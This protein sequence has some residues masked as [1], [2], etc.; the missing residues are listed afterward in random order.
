LTGA[1]DRILAGQSTF[2][3]ELQE[4]ANIL[5]YATAR[6]LVIVDE[7]G[8]GTSTYDGCAAVDSY[9]LLWVRVVAVRLSDVGVRVTSDMPSH[10]E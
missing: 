4:T 7:L 9:F 10:S 1:S 6:S 8:R 3:V 2:M 5:N